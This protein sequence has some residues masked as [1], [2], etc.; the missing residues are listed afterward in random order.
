[1][2]DI[3]LS[4]SAAGVVPI[5]L[6]R[7]AKEF[8]FRGKL[9]PHHAQ[10]SLTD[11]CNLNC[12]FCSCSRRDRQRELGYLQAGRILRNLASLGCKALTITGGGEP[13]MH[14]YF[15]EILEECD[16]LRMKTGLVTNGLLLGETKRTNLLSLIW[17]R[18]SSS[19]DRDIG[20]LLDIAVPMITDI[21]A[22]DWAFSYVVTEKFQ[23]DKLEAI[24]RAGMDLNVTHIRV[25]SDLLDLE[26]TPN[27]YDVQQYMVEAGVDLSR[28]IFQGRKRFTRGSSRCLISLVKPVIGTDGNVYPCCGVQYAMS[29]M[30]LD[31]DPRMSMGDDIQGVY[32][33]QKHFDG[34]VCSRCYYSQ[35][36]DLLARIIT[37]LQHEEFI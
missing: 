34:S 13:L 32:A 26:N 24:I 35:Y 33:I 16:Q 6:I 15:G 12:D 8:Y 21:P 31:F 23:P 28:T 5:K 11:K 7:R 2:T 30:G 19:D 3:Q 9:M 1:M 20:E 25:V 14:P 18:I 17:C 36:N 4:Y 10:I 27:M 22:I 29:D 37:P